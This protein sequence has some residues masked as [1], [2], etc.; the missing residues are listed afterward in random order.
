MYQIDQDVPIP[1]MRHEGSQFPLMEL[2]D[3]ESFFVP[4]GE[5]I[6]RTR[7]SL[8]AAIANHYR[9]KKSQRR[10]TVLTQTEGGIRGMRVW[11]ISGAPAEQEAAA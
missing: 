9:R 7:A 10:F 11:C 1:Q 6:V 5:D 8:T 3:G 4:G 2:S